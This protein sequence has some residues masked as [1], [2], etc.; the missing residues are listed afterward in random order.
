M[1][2]T[3]IAAI[4]LTG[5]AVTFLFNLMLTGGFRA[6]YPWAYARNAAL[7]PICLPWLF[8]DNRQRG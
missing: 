7:W 3:I 6:E 1:T 4:Y 8:L 5:A 2:W